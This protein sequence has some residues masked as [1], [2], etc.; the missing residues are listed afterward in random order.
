[1]VEE[2]RKAG[3]ELQRQANNDLHKYFEILRENEKKY[4]GEIVILLHKK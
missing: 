2:V 3:K 1:M 4:K